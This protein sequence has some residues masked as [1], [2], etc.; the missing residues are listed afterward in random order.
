MKI[1]T[2]FIKN[3]NNIIKRLSILSG[4]LIIMTNTL[5]CS[6]SD[7]KVNDDIP[8]I[9]QEEQD[10]LSL[11]INSNL[12]KELEVKNTNFKLVSALNYLD[13]ESNSWDIT[14][15][16]N[17]YLTVYTKDLDEM[18]EVYINNIYIDI[19]LLSDDIMFNGILQDKKNISTVDSRKVYIDNN[20][21]YE[22][23]I[24]I[25]GQSL[26][27]LKETYLAFN[28]LENEFMIEKRFVEKDYE[29]NGVYGNRIRVVYE[30]LIKKQGE[31]NYQTIDVAT[32]YDIYSSSYINN[33][34]KEKSKTKVLK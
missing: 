32:E 28:N 22:G 7:D 30:L 9:N 6:K 13:E 5:G 17:L 24:P 34:G 33:L 14:S 3:N 27:F 12:K 18:T 25:E 10:I 20:I 4:T 23:I 16:K 21:S 11:Y 31:D 1:K 29:N 8:A 2:D 26:D 15:D 19:S